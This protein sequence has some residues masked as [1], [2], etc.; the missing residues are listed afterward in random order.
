MQDREVWVVVIDDLPISLPCGPRRPSGV[1]CPYHH[2]R[3]NVAIDAATGEVLTTE[4]TGAGPRSDKWSNLGN[5]YDDANGPIPTPVP[6][7]PVPDDGPRGPNNNEP[8]GP[9]PTP[10]PEKNK[11]E[12]NKGRSA[13]PR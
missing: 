4:L 3:F 1:P 11:S 2:P 10:E 9:T 5:P 12:K 13:S 8:G 7:Q 6:D